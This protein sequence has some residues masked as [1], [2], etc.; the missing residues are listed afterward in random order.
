MIHYF[1]SINSS[2]CRRYVNWFLHSELPL[3][4]MH[5]RDWARMGEI[6]APVSYV[7]LQH[8]HTIWGL[9]RNADGSNP[10][11]LNDENQ[12]LK[13]ISARQRACLTQLYKIPLAPFYFLLFLFEYCFWSMLG[14]C[15]YLHKP[16]SAV[17]HFLS[18]FNMAS[19]KFQSCHFGWLNSFWRQITL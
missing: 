8:I 13:Q 9:L 5:F 16:S 17:L 4:S 18:I 19:L 10:A 15:H 3:Q 1:P 7:D 12:I 14:W 2:H 6:L 11:Q